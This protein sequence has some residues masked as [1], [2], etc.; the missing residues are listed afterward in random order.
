MANTCVAPTE[1]LPWQFEAALYGEADAGFLSH[2]ARCA[3]CRDQLDELRQEQ[4]RIGRFIARTDCPTPDELLAHK[5]KLL[6]AKRNEEVGTHVAHCPYCAEEQ[7]HFLGPLIT[8]T[9]TLNDAAT[10][11]DRLS[12]QV[13]VFVARLLP[14]SPELATA[15][16][17]SSRPDAS[18][19]QIYAIDAKDWEVTLTAS[20]NALAHALSGQLLGPSPE[21]LSN[22]NVSAIS[23]TGQVF[24]ATMDTTGWFELNLAV[25]DYALWLELGPE[26]TSD[27]VRLVIDHVKL[28]G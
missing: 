23:S 13:A 5:W 14:Q 17:G 9:V 7:A 8:S 11:R 12:H 18:L 26:S 4:Q 1:I 24:Y 25:G 22:V 15:R 3:F 21:E 28:G 2:L 20:T 6:P 10:L 19:T 16:R 27:L